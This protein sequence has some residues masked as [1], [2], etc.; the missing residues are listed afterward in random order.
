[1]TRLLPRISFRPSS[2]ADSLTA[3]N[4]RSRLACPS[5]FNK[6]KSKCSVETN[7]SCMFS[8]IVAAESRT[9]C[10]SRLR[11]GLLVLVELGIRLSSVSTISANCCI[12][13][14][15]FSNNGA[16]IPSVSSSSEAIRCTGVISGCPITL[17]LFWA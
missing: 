1:M 10:N 6:P 17:A 4:P 16:T 14:L 15:I 2:T 3:F 12:G 13:A 7:S 9:F 8:E 11:S 5:V